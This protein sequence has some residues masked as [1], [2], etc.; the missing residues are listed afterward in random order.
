MID[1]K[2]HSLN[3]ADEHDLIRDG[4]R[5]RQGDGVK[6]WSRNHEKS[7]LCHLMR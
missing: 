2:G 3:E 1:A 5:E 4:R 6:S 7:I